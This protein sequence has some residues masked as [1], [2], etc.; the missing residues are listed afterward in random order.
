LHDL[1][2][3]PLGH[4]IEDDLKVLTRHDENR[5]RF[6]ILWPRLFGNDNEFR[7]ALESGR[8]AVYPSGPSLV[9]E[10]QALIL[11]SNATSKTIASSYPFVA[12]IVG[13][14]ICADLIDY[15][16]RDH[17]STGLP[18]ALG[19]RFA[20]EFYVV[21]SQHP[22]FAKKMAVRITRY[23]RPRTDIVTELVKYLRYRYELTERVLN[24]HAKLAADAMVGKL[25]EM[26]SDAV[27]TDEASARYPNE[28]ARIG[29]TDR[30][31]LSRLIFEG[32]PRVLP[33]G[34][35]DVTSTAD[36]EF[37]RSQALADLDEQVRRRLETEFTWRSDDGLLEHLTELGS[38]EG[39][40]GRLKGV[41]DLAKAVLDRR[42]FKLIGHAESPADMALA[43]EKYQKFGSPTTRQKMERDAAR[44]AQLQHGWDAVVWLPNPDMRLK[45]AGV[46]VDSGDGIAPLDRVSGAGG[47]IVEQHKRLW[48]VSIFA[49]LDVRDAKHAKLALVVLG[50]LKELTDLR[51]VD[52]LGRPVQTLD[53][54]AKTRIAEIANLSP[55][56]VSALARLS[57]AARGDD[58]F[59][60]RLRQWWST[61][62]QN[63]LVKGSPPPDFW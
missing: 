58:S 40:D 19:D 8:S 55:T 15:L 30:D 9:E 35:P 1:C 24:H 49:D 4:T 50:R 61:A 54:L 47:E 31:R 10:L 21:G 46:L 5:G 17:Y 48:S 20:D 12:D 32:D 13:N 59:E 16:Q 44:S 25:L 53:D 33:D 6:D 23:G 51:L 7:Q 34:A 36:P 2:H 56:Q 45:V 60:A 29:R 3:V 37:R 39:A 26:W 18:I 52:W 62:Q 42:L 43:V 28:T 27:W 14:T 22:H 38:A 41:A 63:K 57:L 11:S